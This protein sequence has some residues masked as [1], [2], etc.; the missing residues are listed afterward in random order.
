MKRCLRMIMKYSILFLRPCQE[1]FTKRKSLNE[2]MFVA[3]CVGSLQRVFYIEA[4][5]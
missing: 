1:S 3:E 5:T 4:K 2:T